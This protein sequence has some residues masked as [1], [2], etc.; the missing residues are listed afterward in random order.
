MTNSKFYR[1]F[2]SVLIPGC[3]MNRINHLEHE[4]SI[5]QLP[6]R[7]EFGVR[8][9]IVCGLFTVIGNLNIVGFL[10]C[11]F[12]KS[13]TFQ[14][15]RWKVISLIKSIFFSYPFQFLATNWCC[16]SSQKTWTVAFLR[17]ALQLTPYTRF[18]AKGEKS[19]KFFLV[20]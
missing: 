15:F 12:S 2:L 20:L 7:W 5:C 8:N 10:K 3:H 4:K 16:C 1:P 6:D 9:Y 17:E 18:C 14:E 13:M 11:I 19:I